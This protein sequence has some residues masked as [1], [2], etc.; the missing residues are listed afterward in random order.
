MR[1]KKTIGYIVS[2]CLLGLFIAYVSG[3]RLSSD[4]LVQELNRDMKYSPSTIVYNK[5]I[6]NTAIVISKYGTWIVCRPVQKTFG[7]LWRSNGEYL[8]PIN[9]EK[10]DPSLSEEEIIKNY[11]NQ[12]VWL[13]TPIQDVV[14]RKAA[15]KSISIG[16]V[17]S[18]T[19]F[20]VDSK[21]YVLSGV[22]TKATIEF[23]AGDATITGVVTTWFKMVA[24]QWVI[25]TTK[26]T[27]TNVIAKNE[28]LLNNVMADYD[29][30]HSIYMKFELAYFPK[31][32]SIVSKQ[33]DLDHGKATYT[34]I[35]TA[36]VGPWNAELTYIV[37]AEY[38]FPN[39]WQYKL[40]TNTQYVETMD[41][42]GTWNITLVNRDASGVQVKAKIN[43]MMITGNISQKMVAG[44]PTFVSSLKAT[45]LLNGKTYIIPGI[46][47]PNERVIMSSVRRIIFRFGTS[48]NDQIGMEYQFGIRAGTGEVVANY[49]S[50]GLGF[51]GE[52]VKVK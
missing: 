8:E 12:C 16:Y 41:W 37:D 48:D 14:I 7:F 17:I 13:K 35:K 11:A 15:L 52:L 49:Y 39:G 20:K 18:M 26:F 43:N 44:N 33:L 10:Q 30:A 28:P 2:I 31:N 19:S 50:S 29:G 32:T 9:L 51:S 21:Y 42:S 38:V 6:D 5:S 36:G 24:R 46:A 4:G 27:A 1:L 3:Y 40:S 47:D 22:Q 23:D 45:F 34:I 25:E